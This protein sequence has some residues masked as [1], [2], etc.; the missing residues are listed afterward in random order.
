MDVLF[1]FVV[2]LR[3]L[4]LGFRGACR[5]RPPQVRR[6]SVINVVVESTHPCA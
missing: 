6:G 1:V 3:R 2:S 4:L 5:G